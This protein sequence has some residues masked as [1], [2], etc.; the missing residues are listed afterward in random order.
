MVEALA[1]AAMEDP[2]SE[3]SMTA[4]STLLVTIIEFR[5]SLSNPLQEQYVVFHFLALRHLRSDGGFPPAIDVTQALAHLQWGFRLV[6]FLKIRKLLSDKSANTN[7]MEVLRST[8]ECLH[9]G[10][11]TQM[12]TIHSMKGVLRWHAERHPR[13]PLARWDDLTYTRLYCEGK[14]FA[15]DDFRSMNEAMLSKAED[16]LDELL[17]GERLKTWL[18]MPAYIHD[19]ESAVG[20]LYSF[21]ID[22]RNKLGF[23][24]S[25]FARH[26]LDHFTVGTVDGA[27]QSKGVSSYLS[28]C[29]ALLDMIAAMMHLTCGGAPR[30][31]E[32]VQTRILEGREGKRNLFWIRGKLAW[33]LEYNKSKSQTVSSFFSPDRRDRLADVDYAG[34][35]LLAFYLVGRPS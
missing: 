19:N 31:E 5:G 26:M 6:M 22:P 15:L 28:K 17:M 29:R 9:V 8:I 10:Q 13:A 3:D 4:L 30:A 20:D 23:L 7:E 18:K 27:I 14:Q 35:L 24:N 32:A 12:G 16:L 1:S 11:S 2:T 25:T 34:R 21:L 33:V